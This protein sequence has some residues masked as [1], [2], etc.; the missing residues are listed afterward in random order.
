MDYKQIIEQ[1]YDVQV[2]SIDLID[3]HFGTCI[4]RVETKENDFFCK[5]RP[6]YDENIKNEYEITEF[7]YNK[8]F[9]VARLLK[10]KNGNLGVT[11]DQKYLNIQEFISGTTPE[12]NTAPDWLMK[13]SAE[14]LGRL[15][16]LLRG[17]KQLPNQF[18]ECFFRPDTA[19][20]KKLFL[21]TKLQEQR[22]KNNIDVLRKWKAQIKHLAKISMFSIDTAKLTYANSHGDYHIGQTILNDRNIT[23]IDWA[24]ACGMPVS[25]EIITSYVFAAPEC[26]SGKINADEL[27]EYIRNYKRFSPLTTYDIGAM[28]YLFYFW[29]TICNYL[30]SEEIPLSY[31]SI[32]KLINNMLNWLYGNADKLSYELLKR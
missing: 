22:E 3:C 23:I 20:M 11:V 30:P 15:H 14:L 5:V 31:Q 29:H 6:S 9:P 10:T 27:T 7:L 19:E 2:K 17:F 4:Y 16:V 13:K 18:G 21:E 28:P 32:S 25:L 26:R 1:N 12:I 24:S 8:G